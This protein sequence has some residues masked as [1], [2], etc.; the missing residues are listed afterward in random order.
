MAAADGVEAHLA[1]G[2]EAASV[3]DSAA[4]VEEDSPE[5]EP[6]EAGNY[7]IVLRTGFLPQPE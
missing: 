7:L 1:D 5:A 3:E 2:A 6:A 4:S